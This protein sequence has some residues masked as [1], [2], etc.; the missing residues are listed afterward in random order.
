[1]GKLKQL[2]TEKDAVDHAK[3]VM[4]RRELDGNRPL[5]FY[6]MKCVAIVEPLRAPVK[7]TKLK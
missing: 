1:M 2:D 5:T 3:D 6:V 7:V 4:Q